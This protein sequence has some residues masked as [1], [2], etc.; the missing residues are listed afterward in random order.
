MYKQFFANFETSLNNRAK[1]YL[2]KILEEEIKKDMMMRNWE[3]NGNDP[4]FKQMSEERIRQ[5]VEN[6][7]K[8]ASEIKE[9]NKFMIEQ[10]EK[11]KHRTVEIQKME[12][13]YRHKKEEE[14]KIEDERKRVE[15]KQNQRLY[16]ETLGYQN[17]ITQRMRNNYGSMTEQEKKM[18]KLD[19]RSYK[20]GDTTV[21]S[22]IPGI[23]NIMSVGSSPLVRKGL[24][25]VMQTPG[26]G[27]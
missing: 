8:D 1:M 26:M 13:H 6:R 25:P 23:S 20:D 27:S 16:G 15:G 14:N 22:M 10:H 4:V 11:D 12:L 5:E 17:N 9:F 3:T 2:D 21:H 24:A 7:L 18:N 19:L